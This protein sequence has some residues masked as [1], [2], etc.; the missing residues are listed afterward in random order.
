MIDNAHVR[1][2]HYFLM[3]IALLAF[4][5]PQCTLLYSL[6]P[7]SH[8]IYILRTSPAN[9]SWGINLNAITTM[10]HSLLPSITLTS[11]TWNA[12]DSCG[13]CRNSDIPSLWT[14]HYGARISTSTNLP[15]PTWVSWVFLPQLYLKNLKLMILS[16]VLRTDLGTRYFIWKVNGVVSPRPTNPTYSL[17]NNHRLTILENSLTESYSRLLGLLPPSNWPGSRLSRLAHHWKSQP[18]LSNI[19]RYVCCGWR[20]LNLM[21]RTPTILI[22]FDPNVV[23]ECMYTYLLIAAVMRRKACIGARS[24]LDFQGLK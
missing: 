5:S 1:T 19:A 22:K 20:N 3:A 7:N 6:D 13:H 18:Q 4:P 24:W 9:R 17:S 2:H 10:H 11:C 23:L 16:S 21:A 15:V 14:F 8:T 12:C